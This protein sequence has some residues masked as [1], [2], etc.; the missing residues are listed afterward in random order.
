MAN[1]KYD[2]EAND[3]ILDFSTAVVCQLDKM[4]ELKVFQSVEQYFEMIFS[5]GRRIGKSKQCLGF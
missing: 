5:I 1:A 2:I 3:V 4:K